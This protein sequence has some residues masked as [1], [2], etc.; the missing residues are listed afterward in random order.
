M[1][2]SI[3][4]K[5]SKNKSKSV[6]SNDTNPVNN[7][8]KLIQELQPKLEVLNDFNSRD[9]TIYVSDRHFDYLS[10]VDPYHEVRESISVISEVDQDVIEND[11]GNMEKK[12]GLEDTLIINNRCTKVTEK[13]LKSLQCPFTWNFESNV[14]NKNMMSRIENK[15]GKYNMDISVTKFSLEK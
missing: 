7:S 8:K 6:K 14:W 13:Q 10:V 12:N 4:K 11:V 5:C 3:F 2:W 9:D 15:Y 1:I